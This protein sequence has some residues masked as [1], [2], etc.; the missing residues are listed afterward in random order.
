MPF[1]FKAVVPKKDPF[2]NPIV[3]V[4]KLQTALVHFAVDA[5]GELS[6][7]PEDIPSGYQ[8]TGDLGR[9]WFFQPPGK[10]GAD[11]VIIVA[12]K[13]EYASIVQGPTE[14]P[15]PGQIEVFERRGWK[16]V[17]EV[18]QSQWDNKHRARLA[19]ILQ[20]K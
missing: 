19:A 12:N 13:M 8:R 3:L 18:G 17:T 2:G 4:A 16:N 6:E 1:E 11:L 9:G 5:Q 20:L 7:Y 15:G 14:G 10:Q